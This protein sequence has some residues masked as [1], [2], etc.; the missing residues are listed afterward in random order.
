MKKFNA[1]PTLRIAKADFCCG[2]MDAFLGFLSGVR[3]PANHQ[4]QKSE[5]V[6]VGTLRE[7]LGGG[8][9]K[10]FFL[11]PPG[12]MIQFDDNIFSNGW[13]NTN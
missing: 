9:S 8:N 2:E 12:K 1:R 10:Y 6:K 7:T 5:A 3:S 4:L 13:F 11:L